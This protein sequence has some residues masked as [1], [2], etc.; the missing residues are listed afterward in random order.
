MNLITLFFRSTALSHWVSTAQCLKTV[1]CPQLCKSMD[2]WRWKMRP[3]HCLEPLGNG[4]PAM[5]SKSQNNGVIYTSFFRGL[6]YLPMKETQF[7]WPKNRILEM[8]ELKLAFQIQQQS[9]IWKTAL[10]YG[11]RDFTSWNALKILLLL[12]SELP[13]E[14]LW[15]PTQQHLLCNIS[16]AVCITTITIRYVML[17]A[18]HWQHSECIQPY[19]LN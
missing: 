4:H 17:T 3:S 8:L 1:N 10:T 19:M 12:N 15:H 9:L 6:I 14:T 11:N 16:N 2:Q 13:P 18:H 7:W 5:E